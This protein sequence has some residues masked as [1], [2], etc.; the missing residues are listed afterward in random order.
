MPPFMK[1]STSRGNSD[2]VLRNL[3]KALVGAR[4]PR[5]KSLEERASSISKRI[6]QSKPSTYS[7][8][9]ETSMLENWLRGFDKLFSVVKCPAEFMVDQ[10]A[11]FL[12]EDTRL[13]VD[14]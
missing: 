5:Q 6:A 4:N 14:T 8:K 13:L 11:F 10:A 7:G 9:G 3:V 12:V 2:R 1:R